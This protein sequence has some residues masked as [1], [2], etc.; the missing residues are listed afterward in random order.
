MEEGIKINVDLGSALERCSGD[1]SLLSQV[2]SETL[3]KSMDEQMPKLRQAIETGDIKEV[4]FH[5][6]SMKGASATV[7]FLS[8]SAAAKALDDIAK[9]NSLEGAGGFAD[10]LEEEFKRAIKYFDAHTQAMEE[11]LARCGGDT[12]LFNSIAKEMAESLL[13]EQLASLEEG[14]VAGDAATVD[15]TAVQMMDASDTM[16]AFFLSQLLKPLAKKAQAGSVEGAKEVLE[17]VS[18]EVG[19]L[20]TF[21]G[22]VEEEEEDDDDDGSIYDHSWKG[23]R[24]DAGD[25]VQSPQESLEVA[26]GSKFGNDS[27]PVWVSGSSMGQKKKGPPSKKVKK[28]VKADKPRPKP[29]AYSAVTDIDDEGN[30]V[31]IKKSQVKKAKLGD[32][33]FVPDGPRPKVSKRPRVAWGHRWTILKRLLVGLLLNPQDR[34]VRPRGEV[35]Y[36]E[37]VNAMMYWNTEADTTPSK[38]ITRR[39]E[40]DSNIIDQV[41]CQAIQGLFKGR[42]VRK[43]LAEIRAKREKNIDMRRR[44]HFT[45]GRLNLM[46]KEDGDPTQKGNFSERE[47]ELLD[48]GYTLEEMQERIKKEEEERAVREAAEN[49]LRALFRKVLD[50]KMLG[51][52]DLT[53]NFLLE[54]AGELGIEPPPQGFFLSYDMEKLEAVR[55][56]PAMKTVSARVDQT[57]E[58]I[59]AQWLLQRMLDEG[60]ERT[61]KVIAEQKEL[62]IYGVFSLVEMSLPELLTLLRDSSVHQTFKDHFQEDD[63]IFKDPYAVNNEMSGGS[64]GSG[65]EKGKNMEVGGSG[66][67][68]DIAHRNPVGNTGQDLG[69]PRSHELGRGN[70]SPVRLDENAEAMLK[71][72]DRMVQIVTSQKEEL[73]NLLSETQVRLH[74]ERLEKKKILGDLD[75]ERKKMAAEV[76]A[77]RA[78]IREES[79]R[80][81]Q[82]L[83]E[84]KQR[85]QEMHENI[86][87]ASTRPAT[88]GSLRLSARA[89]DRG[90]AEASNDDPRFGLVRGMSMYGATEAHDAALADNT[91]G[92][93]SRQPS[94]GVGMLGRQESMRARPT[95]APAGRPGQHMHGHIADD[96][97]GATLSEA[98]A[99]AQSGLSDSVQEEES[100]GLIGED[101]EGDGSQGSSE[102][103]SEKET[104]SAEEILAKKRPKLKSAEQIKAAIEARQDELIQMQRQLKE[105]LHHEED[106]KHKRNPEDELRKMKNAE[107]SKAKRLQAFRSIS[108]ADAMGIAQKAPG[109]RA[110]DVSGK[111]KPSWL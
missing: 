56:H 35:R 85:Q 14:I 108:T 97:M 6:H 101:E 23:T 22:N 98:L 26:A 41:S 11:A 105:A 10:D 100:L 82:M 78:H 62:N 13:P 70:R 21:W 8:L 54:C 66:G 28:V 49:E 63:P 83:E 95:T 37:V 110:F 67:L 5:A 94:M 79:A 91:A 19:K 47:L 1:V 42:M 99:K 106:L 73:A 32:P 69:I 84:V 59:R 31:Y 93:L 12:E 24:S 48:Q 38:I 96:R 88:A 76:A 72:S 68:D 107:A 45:Q 39:Q 74:R 60:F 16:G 43:K 9:A 34:L 52:G 57:A 80:T 53:E 81:S 7:G 61:L 103:K 90:G 65:S 40:W 29:S 55:L 4:H 109:K 20:G 64:I 86:R 46:G 18:A 51:D 89:G 111:G 50:K 33:D 87:M 17:E 30:V 75:L 92:M 71:R 2:V 44:R 15:S 25:D 104:E 27:E 3:H 36:D 58:H 102:Q 77:E